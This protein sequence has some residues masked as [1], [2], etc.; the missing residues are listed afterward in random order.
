MK[1][2]LNV[3]IKKDLYSYAK[4]P[5]YACQK[6]SP[7]S[8]DTCVI[9]QRA[10]DMSIWKEPY[11]R[12]SKETYMYENTKN[13]YVWMSQEAYAYM[14]RALYMNVKRDVY[15]YENSPINA[16]PKRCTDYRDLFVVPQCLR[17][18][19]KE[20]YTWMSKETTDMKRGTHY[21]DLFV[22]PQC[23]CD[24]FIWKE[25][26]AQMSKEASIYEKSHYTVP[27]CARQQRPDCPCVPKETHI[28]EM[29]PIYMERDLCIWKRPTYMERDLNIWKE[30]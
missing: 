23:L 30:T 16:C 22:V 2:A 24:M 5:I 7:T 14:K 18:I 25:P 21:R 10:R 9:S 20:P 19:W 26:Y 27:Q 3:N 28:Y 11:T 6:R 17:E 15:R 4:N 29:R 12:M 1:R 13:P 8:R